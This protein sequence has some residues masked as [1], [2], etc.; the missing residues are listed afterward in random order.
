PPA[1]TSN[2]S[3]VTVCQG[4]SATFSSSAK[5]GG[6]TYQE[7][8]NGTAIGGATSASYMIASAQPNCSGSIYDVVVSGTCSPDATS[9]AATL[10]VNTPPAITSNPSDVTVCQ[11]GSATFSSSA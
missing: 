9:S 7:R 3:D 1:I 11:G 2:P 5:I 6:I 4:G 10:T 8:K